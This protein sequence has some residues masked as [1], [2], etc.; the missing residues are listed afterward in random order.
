M[1]EYIEL[2]HGETLQKY[3]EYC[4]SNGKWTVIPPN[5]IGDTIPNCP[6]TKW[7]R[8]QKDISI[9]DYQKHWYSFFLGKK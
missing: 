2:K 3:D 5:F 7:R 4:T 8:L 9:T 1:N 6:S